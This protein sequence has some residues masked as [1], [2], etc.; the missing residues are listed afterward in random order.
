MKGKLIVFLLVVFFLQLSSETNFDGI[1]AN[2]ILGHYL[3]ADEINATNSRDFYETDPPVGPV[4]N[5]AEFEPM[6]GVLIRYQFG[7]PYALIAELSQETTVTTIVSSQAQSNTVLGYYN[8]NGV[9]TD[10]C[11]FLI[12][13]S[14]SY[15][16]R[17]YGPWF[18]IDGNGD[19][20]I[21]NFP[22]NRPRPNDDDIPIEMAEFLDINLFG[23]D[24]Y[25]TGGNYMTDGLGISASTDLVIPENPSLSVEEIDQLMLDYLGISNYHL[26]PDPNNT[27]IDHIDCWSKFLAVDKILLRSVPESHPQ[28]DEIEEVADYYA[29]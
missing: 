27:Y 11:N 29:E 22:Y 16:T 6:Q 20:G 17:D 12:A 1:A 2:P 8:S 26:I 14:D 25:H 23:M 5:I 9:N 13:P 19:F 21:V 10:N 24:I 18:V 28:Y 3:S 15:W 4:H 7:I